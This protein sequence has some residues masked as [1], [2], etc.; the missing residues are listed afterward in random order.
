MALVS[1][2]GRMKDMS[3]QPFLDYSKAYKDTRLNTLSIAILPYGVAQYLTSVGCRCYRGIKGKFTL[4]SV[5]CYRA[6]VDEQRCSVH[7]VIQ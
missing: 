3:N 7:S 6:K 1:A 2:S 5:I 4:V